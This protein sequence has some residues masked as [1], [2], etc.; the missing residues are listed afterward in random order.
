MISH[1]VTRRA[2]D[3][4]ICIALGLLPA[5]VLSQVV[6][7]G[8]RLVTAGAALG[9]AAALVLTRLLSSLLHEVSA[10]D[11]RAFAGAVLVL[12]AAGTL[13]AYIPARR[14]SRTDPAGVLREQ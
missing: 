10:V 14:A 5:R 1:H 12:V 11:P 4:G 6:G 3:Y 2:R 7:R 8:L 13:A 9:I